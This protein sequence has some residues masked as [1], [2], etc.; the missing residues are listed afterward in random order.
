MCRLSSQGVNRTV[1]DLLRA[2]SSAGSPAEAGAVTEQFFGGQASE[3]RL[4]PD[5]E[6][7]VRATSQE[8]LYKLLTRP[9]LR[10]IL[11]A[12]EDD[13][14]SSMSEDQRC[15]RNLTVE[16]IMPQQWKDHWDSG[17]GLLE[18]AQRDRLVQTLGNLTLITLKLN[19]SISNGPW[20][21]QVAHARG[22]KHDGKR[23]AIL[24]HSVLKL[25]ADLA[26][27][28]PDTWEDGDIRARGAAMADRA[29]A[30]WARPKGLPANAPDA[31][32]IPASAAVLAEPAKAMSSARFAPQH[33]GKYRPLWTWLRGQ[34]TDQASAS[35]EEIEDV[36]NFKLPP[37]VESTQPSGTGPLEGS[38]GR[39]RMLGGERWRS[40]WWPSRLSSSGSSTSASGGR[41]GPPGRAPV[42]R[43]S[44]ICG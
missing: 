25:N 35:F 12:L 39:S 6:W 42:L 44:S 1:V 37:S 5:D 28:H 22:L 20:S 18:A 36:L 40:T 9:R 7:F 30:I 17:L 29:A 26:V 16:H 10:M 8:P 41:P 4:W 31:A 3:T 32:P 15:P 19:S 27:E 38:A 33:S 13:A 34:K 14:R 2:L 24:K 21:A 23:A 43:T 11:E